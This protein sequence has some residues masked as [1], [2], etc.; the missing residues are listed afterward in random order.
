MV[1]VITI[2]IE[3]RVKFSHVCCR[4]AQF[5]IMCPN[6]LSWTNPRPSPDRIE[7]PAAAFEQSLSPRSGGTAQGGIRKRS[8]TFR[9]NLTRLSPDPGR[10]LAIMKQS[11]RPIVIA[12]PGLWRSTAAP[13]CSRHQPVAGIEQSVAAAAA[14]TTG[15]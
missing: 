5:L 10:R 1:V 3:A 6:A 15:S 7:K 13:K 12:L 8:S 14:A 9:A 11:T 4:A 2:T